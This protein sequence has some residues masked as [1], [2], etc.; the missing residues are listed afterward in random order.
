[1]SPRRSPWRDM[2]LAPTLSA[3]ASVGREPATSTSLLT[4]FPSARR[5]S[6]VTVSTGKLGSLFCPHVSRRRSHFI[7]GSASKAGQL[8]QLHFLSASSN[9]AFPVIPEADKPPLCRRHTE[10][11]AGRR[12]GS[13]LAQREPGPLTPSPGSACTRAHFPGLAPG[14]SAWNGHT[15]GPHTSQT[16]CK[17]RT[18][19]G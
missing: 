9:L 4:S 1:M 11:Q 10:A 13:Q 3:T 2:S 12:T 18:A 5:T 15:V 16:L 8:L 7:P 6:A 14:A 17:S 19:A